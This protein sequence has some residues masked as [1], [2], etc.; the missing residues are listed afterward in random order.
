MCGP[1]RKTSQSPVPARTLFVPRK[2][3]CLLAGQ[4]YALTESDIAKYALNLPRDY[5]RKNHQRP[6][7]PTGEKMTEKEKEFERL[8]KDHYARL[9]YYA[10]T[11]IDDTETCRDI[12]SDVF[13]TLWQEY[14]TI[15]RDTLTAYLYACVKNR[16]IDL[17]RRRS[18]KE[19]YVTFYSLDL[20]GGLLN[21]DAEEQER[22]ARIEKV[23]EH[24]P[25]QRQFVLKECF[26]HKKT[27]KEVADILGITTE[28]IKKHIKTALKNLRDEF[29]L[30]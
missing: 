18:V 12:V 1:R 20:K 16:C 14:D 9:Y 26:Y 15:R 2:L 11:F 19:R 6:T 29:L 27:Y 23:I 28:G 30:K 21:T 25:A 4:I 24:M 13:E 22:I 5:I 3:S 8:F 17:L 7:S 10:L